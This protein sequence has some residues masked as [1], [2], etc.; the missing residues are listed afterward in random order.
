MGEMWGA[1]AASW[2][3]QAAG[4]ER[5]SRLLS[6]RQANRWLAGNGG[7]GS[8]ARATAVPDGLLA[9]ATVVIGRSLAR[10]PRVPDRS[11]ARAPWVP[12]RSLARAPRVPDRSLARATVVLRGGIVFVL[13]QAEFLAIVKSLTPA[14]LSAAAAKILSTPLSYGVYGNVAQVS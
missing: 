11:L 6:R 5:I 4:D 7:D 8:L 12:D 14:D 10:A 9:F 2:P 1:A 3:L 13:V